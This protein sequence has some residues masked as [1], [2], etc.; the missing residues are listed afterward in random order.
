MGIPGIT[1]PC[2]IASKGVFSLPSVASCL[3]I[4]VGLS[5]PLRVKVLERVSVIAEGA[6]MS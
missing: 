1:M 6:M 2:E 5:P 3:I 4:S